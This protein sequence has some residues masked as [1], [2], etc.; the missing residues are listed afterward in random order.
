MVCY[1]SKDTFPKLERSRILKRIDDKPV[2]SL[3]CFFVAKAFRRKGISIKLLEAAVNYAKKEEA[4]IVEGYPIEP[5][6][7]WT[8]DP[9]AYMGLISIFH[10][11]GFV[12]AIRRSETHPIMRYVI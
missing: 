4:S 8:P 9:F 3:V 7:G 11:I 10:K 12:E 6:K 1:S 5:K 2:W